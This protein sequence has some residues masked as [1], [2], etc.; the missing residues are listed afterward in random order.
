MASMI[1]IIYSIINSKYSET[2]TTVHLY[3]QKLF[4]TLCQQNNKQIITI[5]IVLDLVIQSV[6]QVVL[7]ILVKDRSTF[8][9][10]N[11]QLVS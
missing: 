3:S 1:L 7:N 5:A 8:Q 9:K 6:N 11:S 10:Y 2:S 4:T